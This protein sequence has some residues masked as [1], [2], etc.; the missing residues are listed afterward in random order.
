MTDSKHT[1][2]PW[3]ASPKKNIV[4][5][6]Q[7]HVQVCTDSDLGDHTA[8]SRL[9]AEAPALLDALEQMLE[10]IYG[11]SPEFVYDPEW[12]DV[13]MAARATID[14]AKGEKS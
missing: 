11:W 5:R 2:G 12:T 3:S 13:E 8:D 7:R 14:R 4:C 1:R 6:I 9:I 10:W